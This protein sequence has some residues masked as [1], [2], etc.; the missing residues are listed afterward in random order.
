MC[1]HMQDEL[2]YS[3]EPFLICT[4]VKVRLGQNAS[5]NRFFSLDTWLSKEPCGSNCEE[6][7]AADT[8]IS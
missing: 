5:E 1:P 3:R 8:I 6:P 7:T 4:Y 2:H